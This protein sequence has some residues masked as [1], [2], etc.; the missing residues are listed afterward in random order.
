MRYLPNQ[1]CKARRIKPIHLSHIQAALAHYLLKVN[2]SDSRL[3]RQI[4]LVAAALPV[5]RPLELRLFAHEWAI[6]SKALRPVGSNP[7]PGTKFARWFALYTLLRKTFV[8][9]TAGSAR[10]QV[11][12]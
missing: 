10:N 7:T 9:A 12:P 8:F 4:L 1:P 5:S 2:G 3:R 11:Q 6:V